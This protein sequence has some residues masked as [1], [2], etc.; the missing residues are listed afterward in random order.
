MMERE[1]GA[2]D[3]SHKHNS[4]CETSKFALMDFT[5]NRSKERPTMTIRGMHI[6]PS[7]NHQLRWKAHATYTIAKG[8]KH[9]IMLRRLSSTTWA[10]V[11]KITYG[12]NH[13]RTLRGSQA[14]I[15]ATGAMHTSPTDSLLAHA[16]LPPVPLLLQKTLYNSALHL[17]S[18][19]PNHPLHPLVR[20]AAKRNLT[21]DVGVVPGTVE[22]IKPCPVPPSASPL[23]CISI[24]TDK[25]EAIA[26][27]QE[28]VDRTQIFTD[29]SGNNGLVGTAAVMYVDKRHVATLCYHL[30]P[31]TKHTVF[32]AEAV[33]LVLA[34]HLLAMRNETT[35]PASI[36]ADNQAAIRARHHILLDFRSKLCKISKMEKLSRNDLT[37]RWI[38]GHQNIEG[39]ELAD[40]EAKAVAEGT[41]KSS[42]VRHLPPKLC[43]PLPQ[44]IS[45][46]KQQ[47][48][49]KV[50]STWRKEW[51]HS[52]RYHCTSNI[53]P[54]LPSNVFLKLTG[55]L[56]KKQVGLYV[57]LRTNHAPLNQHLHRFQARTTHEHLYGANRFIM[58]QQHHTS[59]TLKAWALHNKT[60]TSSCN[61]P[62][63]TS[64][65]T[66]HQVPVA[67]NRHS[68]VDHRIWSRVDTGRTERPI[69][70]NSTKPS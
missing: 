47:H 39:N 42:P 17:A 46:L 15:A 53:D 56:R 67:T 32:E 19:P 60:G 3:W 49:S 50:M 66:T 62:V 44:S 45:A 55:T 54:H 40:K 68:T 11:P 2:Y 13:K 9:V 34:A 4:H 23:H 18:L 38:A 21:H 26:A 22:T 27:Q 52:P 51:K 12:A 10:V 41:D 69:N 65:P 43:S 57:Q 33:A 36:L 7:P 6:D 24:A 35:Y 48:N 30:G 63:P 28:L 16:Y 59:S 1:G 14:A 37:V 29:G 25:D 5:L 8:A 64:N 61:A 58:L 20:R 31:D 70:F